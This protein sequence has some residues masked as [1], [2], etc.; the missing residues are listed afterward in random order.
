MLFSGGGGP[1]ENN[2]DAVVL[3]SKKLF[4]SLDFNFLSMTKPKYKRFMLNPEY[5]KKCIKMFIPVLFI[6]GLLPG[7]W[8]GRGKSSGWAVT[9][10]HSHPNRCF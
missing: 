3:L 6:I 7:S 10:L 8:L 4:F 2:T 5:R 1:I 9:V